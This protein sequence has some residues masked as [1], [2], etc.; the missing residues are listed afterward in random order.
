MP[1]KWFLR[2]KKGNKRTGNLLGVQESEKQQPTQETLI[3][4]S[5]STLPYAISQWHDQ[6]KVENQQVVDP[7]RKSKFLGKSDSESTANTP[8]T[9]P[10]ELRRKLSLLEE[11]R[12]IFQRR[13]Y[14]TSQDSS[15]DISHDTVVAA[16]IGS[17]R[18]DSCDPEN[19]VKRARHIS[20]RKFDTFSTFEGTFDEDTGVGYLAG[21]EEVHSE[22]YL[23]DRRYGKDKQDTHLV[24]DYE[25]PGSIM[26]Q[27]GND[28]PE[29]ST[30]LSQESAVRKNIRC[31][32]RKNRN[33]TIN[34]SN[35]QTTLNSEQLLPRAE[36]K[37]SWKLPYEKMHFIFHAN[38]HP[39]EK[40]LPQVEGHPR[41]LVATANYREK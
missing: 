11:K 33:L 5:V 21:I 10:I 19:T 34:Q 41:T 39:A 36:C 23:S 16:S 4:C 2:K 29:G 20:V 13:R 30:S 6:S 31:V 28:I 9:P 32:H 26:Q 25:E 15:C 1:K 3:Q 17:T 22:N 18:K 8:T 12:A 7:A 14:E 35:R 40:I 38:L 37:L 27:P 24:D